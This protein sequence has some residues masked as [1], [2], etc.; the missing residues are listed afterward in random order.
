MDGS[1]YTDIVVE[2]LFPG[3]TYRAPS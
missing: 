3:V 2:K 1:A